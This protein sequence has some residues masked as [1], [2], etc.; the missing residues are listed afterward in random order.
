[1]TASFY[2]PKC[3]KNVLPSSNFCPECGFKFNR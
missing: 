1:D 2:C 3:K